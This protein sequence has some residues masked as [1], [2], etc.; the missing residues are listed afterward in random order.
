V[1][2]SLRGGAPIVLSVI[3]RHDQM[4]DGETG[5]LIR[6]GPNLIRLGPELTEEAGEQIG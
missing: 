2:A 4:E 1:S 3:A 5:P 6:E